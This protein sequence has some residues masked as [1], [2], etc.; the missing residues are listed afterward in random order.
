MEGEEENQELSSCCTQCGNELP[1]NENG[2]CV[3][4]QELQ[5]NSGFCCKNCGREMPTNADGLCMDCE[6][7]ENTNVDYEEQE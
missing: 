2:L 6:A 1:L 5:Q 4:C 7:Q 3:G